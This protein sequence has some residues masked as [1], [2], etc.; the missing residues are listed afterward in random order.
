MTS[1][2]PDTKKFFERL[3]AN[4]EPTP[5][6]E[7]FA[8]AGAQTSTPH[9][10]RGVRAVVAA[11]LV[12]AAIA[13][14]IIV[15]MNNNG[16]APVQVQS[17]SPTSATP[18]TSP[19]VASIECEGEAL[20]QNPT[21]LPQA[22]ISSA[23]EQMI[24][25]HFGT[26][27]NSLWIGKNHDVGVAATDI[28]S[29]DREWART[30]P[31]TDGTLKLVEVPYSLAQIKTFATRMQQDIPVFHPPARYQPGPPSAPILGATTTT[32][33]IP[34]S[35]WPKGLYDAGVN[36]KLDGSPQQYV[37]V[38]VIKVRHC[39]PEL[40]AEAA[41]IAARHNVPVD[42]LRLFRTG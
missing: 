20:D 32:T 16:Q 41:R 18:T 1:P 24:L 12:A 9:P 7:I 35:I 27:F 4:R 37:N 14:G 40:T 11:G 33:D 15:S 17:P 23:S 10:H 5:Y 8:R 42:A 36:L 21:I 22:Q 13:A 29:A 19:G 26:R 38:V 28:T 30:V 39:S 2:E 34:D 31:V 6:R 3:L 25:E